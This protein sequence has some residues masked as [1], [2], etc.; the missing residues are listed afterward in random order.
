MFTN[1]FS[2]CM[3]CEQI[4]TSLMHLHFIHNPYQYRVRLLVNVNFVGPLNLTPRHNRYILVMVGFFQ[5]VGVGVVK[6]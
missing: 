2:W 5:V 4:R 3:V 1:L 6:S